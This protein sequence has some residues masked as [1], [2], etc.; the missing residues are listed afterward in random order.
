MLEELTELR[1]RNTRIAIVDDLSDGTIDDDIISE[2]EMVVS[3]LVTNAIRH[4]KPLA[5]G[6][7]RVP[8]VLQPYMRGKAVITA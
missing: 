1:D 4:A 5:D 3:E 8:A 6:S 2:C 7:I